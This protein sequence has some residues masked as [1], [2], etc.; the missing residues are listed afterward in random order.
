MRGALRYMK[1]TIKRLSICSCGFP[2]LNESI[3]L[4]AE[5]E[6]EPGD[7][8]PFTLICGGCHWKHAVTGVWVQAT[9]GGR[10][11]YL[12]QTIFETP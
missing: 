9:A 8:A 11:G 1:T 4:G 6:I 2:V 10:P 3:K 7:T 5:Y 12:P